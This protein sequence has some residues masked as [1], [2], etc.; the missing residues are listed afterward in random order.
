MCVCVFV[1]V[2]VC[3]FFKKVINISISQNVINID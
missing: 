2:S 3:V 1:C